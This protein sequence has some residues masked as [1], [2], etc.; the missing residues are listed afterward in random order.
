MSQQHGFARRYITSDEIPNII[1]NQRKKD[2][3]Y[4]GDGE[5]VS[6]LPLQ[7]TGQ[8]Q[9]FL[10]R[11]TKLS[12][13]TS[14]ETAAVLRRMLTTDRQSNAESDA[15]DPLCLSCRETAALLYSTYIPG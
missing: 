5:I 3:N 7:Q 14:T 13:H 10:P 9:L 15:R 4:G 8:G 2:K 11:P 6:S 1:D 12:C